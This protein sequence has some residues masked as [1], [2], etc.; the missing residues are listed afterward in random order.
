MLPIFIFSFLSNFRDF[1][2][3]L[4]EFWRILWKFWEIFADF[5]LLFQIFLRDFFRLLRDFWNNIWWNFSEFLRNFSEFFIFKQ[6]LKSFWRILRN[7]RIY[8][9]IFE[10]F[11]EIIEKIVKN[12]LKIFN[13]KHENRI[14]LI[15][16]LSYILINSSHII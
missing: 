3:I 16:K 10:N 1:W 14:F 11:K 7:L 8:A 6:F 12:V 4:I 9:E 2:R 5:W 13:E 15:K